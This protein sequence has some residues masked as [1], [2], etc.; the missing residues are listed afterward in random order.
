MVFAGAVAVQQPAG[1]GSGRAGASD[2]LEKTV[3]ARSPCVVFARVVPVLMAY[4]HT[5][6]IEVFACG[7][8]G[9]LPGYQS[10]INVHDPVTCGHL[11]PTAGLTATS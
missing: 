3:S 11:L 7:F 9:P 4:Y 5:C 6:I 1:V 10:C 8:S 2:R